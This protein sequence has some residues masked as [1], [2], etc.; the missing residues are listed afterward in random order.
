M[1]YKAV[2]VAG[3]HVDAVNRDAV[4]YG[5]EFEH[6]AIFAV[7]FA[8]I[9]EVAIAQSVASGGEIFGGDRFAQLWRV[10]DGAFEYAVVVEDSGYCIDIA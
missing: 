7:P 2:I 4:D 9:C 1:G 3:D 10:D 6:G 8:D 5:F